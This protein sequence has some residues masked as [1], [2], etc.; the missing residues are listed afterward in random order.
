[1]KASVSLGHETGKKLRL[2]CAALACLHIAAS[3]FYET[4]LFA[5]AYPLSSGETV[6]ICAL[7]KLLGAGLIALLWTF[8]YRLLSGRFSGR[9]QAVFFLSFA[10]AL[11]LIIPTYPL[12]YRYELDNLLVYSGAVRYAPLYWHHYLTACAYAASY[13]LFPHPILLPIVQ[14]A[15]LCGL[16]SW[17]HEGLRQ[18]GYKRLAWAA[19]AL[20]ALPATFYL[21]LSPYRNCLY[22]LLCLYVFTSCLFC[23][24]DARAL[25]GRELAKL[26][27]ALAVMGAWR[28]EG[29]LYCLLL[30]VV[31]LTLG[32]RRWVS[33]LS[34]TA[35]CA[36]LAG[37][38]MLPQNAGMRKSEDGIGNNY[39][40]ISMMNA[41]QDVFL[42]PNA[43]LNYAESEADVAVVASFVPLELLCEHGLKGYRWHNYTSG[44]RINVSGQSPAAIADFTRAYARLVLHNPGIFLKSQLNRFLSAMDIPLRFAVP[45]YGGVHAEIDEA[46]LYGASRVLW[47]AGGDAL[48]ARS[49]WTLDL[50]SFSGKAH[51]LMQGGVKTLFPIYKKLLAYILPAVRLG[52]AIASLVFSVLLFKRKKTVFPLLFALLLLCELAAVVVMA[53]EGNIAYYYP[54]GYGFY[55]LAGFTGAGLSEKPPQ[56][57]QNGRDTL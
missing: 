36:A 26:T 43:N 10:A 41:L 15:F 46:E 11:V 19:L 44:R 23:W 1:M 7:S 5:A 30:P 21:G 12:M 17:L 16:V 54:V 48:A 28:T 45:A 32:K 50:T 9:A 42:E 14:S 4:I 49:Y 27:I 6:L 57:A 34:Y 51:S 2:V 33:A 25:S 55:L 47:E 3:F 35:A 37:A 20:F 18:R 22:T 8:V 56:Q 52:A 39:T 13:M 40:L 53:P 24:L 38:L 31:L 29:L